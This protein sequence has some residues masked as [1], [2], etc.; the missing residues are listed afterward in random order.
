MP[1]SNRRVTVKCCGLSGFDSGGGF[2]WGSSSWGT[3]QLLF[4]E[5]VFVFSVDETNSSEKVFEVRSSRPQPAGT[6]RAD[7]EVQTR[8]GCEGS[9]M[10]RW[11]RWMRCDRL[12]KNQPAEITVFQ[13][14]EVQE[15][16]AFNGRRSFLKLRDCGVHRK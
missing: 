6:V 1:T 3:L 4:I 7:V 13:I 14:S 12:A 5:R 2:F 11:I 15:S 10:S 9:G 16:T 8:A